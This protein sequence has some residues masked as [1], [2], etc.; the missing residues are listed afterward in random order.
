MIC[1]FVLLMHRSIISHSY[2]D[3]K[4]DSE[5][6]QNILGTLITSREES[7]ACHHNEVAFYDKQIPLTTCTYVSRNIFKW[8]PS[9]I[10]SILKQSK[11]QTKHP[12]PQ[13]K[14]NNNNKKK[15]NVPTTKLSFTA[16][17]SLFRG[18]AILWWN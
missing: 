14:N 6:L 16:I 3:V 1:S 13:K 17:R 4:I 11:I 8:I 10:I 15:N 12:P 5:G 7:S 2:Q 9:S 18:E